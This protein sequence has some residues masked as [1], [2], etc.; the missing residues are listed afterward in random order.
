M[1]TTSDEPSRDRR[2]TIRRIVRQTYREAVA[3]AFILVIA[4]IWVLTVVDGAPVT[5]TLTQIQQTF[6]D[7]LFF[8]FALASAFLVF[9]ERTLRAAVSLYRDL[10]GE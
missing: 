9:G 3:L 5:V 8:I 10:R 1:S 4:G 2:S 7:T 6:V